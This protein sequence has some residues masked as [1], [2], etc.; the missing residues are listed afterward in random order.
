MTT[1][2]WEGTRRG[3]LHGFVSDSPALAGHTTHYYAVVTPAQGD[4]AFPSK[5]FILVNIRESEVES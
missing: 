1:I 4:P 3:V 5:K 2:R